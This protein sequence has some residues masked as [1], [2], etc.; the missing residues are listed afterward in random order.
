MNED[1]TTDVPKSVERIKDDKVE[2]TVE[3]FILPVYQ[4]DNNDKRSS[5]VR[6]QWKDVRVENS[7]HHVKETL[8]EIPTIN[9]N[10]YTRDHNQLEETATT[11]TPQPTQQHSNHN[12][13]NNHN[14]NF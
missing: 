14:G 7:L 12:Q 4:V 9:P 6:D 3:S 2:I 13:P 5:E 1:E 11:T 10:D 8:I